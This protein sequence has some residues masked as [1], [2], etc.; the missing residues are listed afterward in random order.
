MVASG[1][2][3][4][5]MRSTMVSIMDRVERIPKAPLQPHLPVA[6]AIRP[7]LPPPIWV[8]AAGLNSTS[9]SPVV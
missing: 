5:L 2:Y 3:A 6:G 8:T 1:A 9:V 7:M 4:E